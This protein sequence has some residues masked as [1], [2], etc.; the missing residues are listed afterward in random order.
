MADLERLM[1]EIWQQIGEP[2]DLN[3]S[4]D[5]QYG[6]SP[7]L[8]WV[9]N[10]AQRR[11]ATWKDPANGHRVRIRSLV[12]DLYFTSTYYEEELD[13]DATDEKTVILPS[14]DVLG[15]DDC[16]NGWTLEIN[17][18]ARVI[19]DY[20]G[21]SYTATLSSEFSSTPEEDDEYKLYKNFYYLMDPDHAWI[22]EH[23][24]LPATTD[25]S[26][27]TGNLLEVL[28]IVDL[29]NE[30]GLSVSR[31]TLYPTTNMGSPGA[32][33]SWIRLGNKLI[34]NRPQADD[35]SFLMEY[36]R[37]P[38][39]MAGNDSEPELPEMYQ[40]AIV[41][42]GM[43]WGF[44]RSQDYTAAWAKKQDF[45]EYMKSTVSQ[46]EVAGDRSELYGSL[47]RN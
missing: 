3:P 24:S 44:N 1:N 37:L 30:R 10:E 39:A 47:Q 46:Y 31:G 43:W 23:I 15:E 28:K 29:N 11:V 26:R 17:N 42:W 19:I 5:D 21:D 20:D 25:T 7:L 38:L 12:S 18:E 16:Y 8:M 4:T 2:S 36:Y 35:Y 22:S 45:N 40:Y 13:E 33:D 34:F 9:C 6:G 27:A 14:T 32:P 41:L